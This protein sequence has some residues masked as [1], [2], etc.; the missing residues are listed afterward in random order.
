MFIQGTLAA[1]VTMQFRCT[2]AQFFIVIGCCLVSAY[3][4][5]QQFI[6]EYTRWAY[7]GGCRIKSWRRAYI[8]N[9]NDFTL[10]MFR[11]GPDYPGRF[12]SDDALARVAQW[13]NVFFLLFICGPAIVELRLVSWA[14]IALGLIINYLAIQ[15]LGSYILSLFRKEASLHSLSPHVCKTSLDTIN[16]LVPVYLFFPNWPQTLE[17]F[18]PKPMHQNCQS[19]SQ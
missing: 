4:V 10:S 15:A 16:R 1:T 11:M 3:Y 17:Y 19:Y 9:N 7:C 2:L 14:S 18:F 13:R 8:K 12:K 6:S 5:G